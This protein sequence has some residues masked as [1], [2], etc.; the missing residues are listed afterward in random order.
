M[1]TRVRETVGLAL[2]TAFV[3]ARELLVGNISRADRL[4]YRLPTVVALGA[5]GAVGA[6]L[7]IPA[8]YHAVET[9]HGCAVTTVPGGGGA[10]DA[11]LAA[12]APLHLDTS[13]AKLQAALTYAAQDG[14]AEAIA[15]ATDGRV[16]PGEGFNTCVTYNPLQFGNQWNAEV[17]P[18]AQS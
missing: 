3:T 2:G 10:I 14:Q 13:D 15:Q 1:S 11:A 7:G 8:A 16:D 4:R 12:R 9:D 17:H 5:A 6:V 18:V